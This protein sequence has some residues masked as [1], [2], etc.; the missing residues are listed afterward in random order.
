MHDQLESVQS[1]AAG[2]VP[3]SSPAVKGGGNAA[4]RLPRSRRGIGPKITGLAH[5]PRRLPNVRQNPIH[6]QNVR[7]HDCRA[8]NGSQC[9]VD[10]PM[11]D[12]KRVVPLLPSSA[13]RSRSTHTEQPLRT[14]PASA[15]HHDDPG[16]YVSCGICLVG[17]GGRTVQAAPLR[18]KRNSSNHS[19]CADARTNLMRACSHADIPRKEGMG[20]MNVQASSFA[21]FPAVSLELL[22]GI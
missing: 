9:K 16:S 19:L 12:R 3:T 4:G 1:P 6:N 14:Y 11:I 21:A 18:S 10:V 5:R 15:H 8:C 22:M 17:C 20:R 7:E 2:G 13:S